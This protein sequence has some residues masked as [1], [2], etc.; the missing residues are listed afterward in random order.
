MI[1]QYHNSKKKVDQTKGAAILPRE[2]IETQNRGGRGVNEGCW[3]ASWR[4]RRVAEI[5][6]EN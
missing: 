3:V 5:K 4:V 6:I 2:A 1:K